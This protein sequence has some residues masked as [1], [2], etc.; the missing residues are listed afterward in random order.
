MHSSIHA[1]LSSDARLQDCGLIQLRLTGF[2]VSI[3]SI[4]GKQDFGDGRYRGGK[5]GAAVLLMISG[6]N[7][8]L[9]ASFFPCTAT[10]I[11]LL[12][13]PPSSS[14]NPLR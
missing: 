4:T 12:I 14:I 3:H 5:V 6:L 2:F 7:A 13:S 11:S 9:A 10:S 8:P 1:I